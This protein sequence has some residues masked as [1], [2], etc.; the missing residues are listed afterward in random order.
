MERTVQRQFLCQQ[1]SEENHKAHAFRVTSATGCQYYKLFITVPTKLHSHKAL[2]SQEALI[3][4]YVSNNSKI[5]FWM[6]KQVFNTVVEEH[7]KD[8]AGGLYHT[9]LLPSNL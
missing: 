9:E 4:R 7:G 3:F 5:G 8:A 1:Y 2:H 6:W